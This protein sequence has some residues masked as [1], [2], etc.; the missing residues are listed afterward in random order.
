[1]TTDASSAYVGAA[2][3]WAAGPERLYDRLSD[4]VLTAVSR[5]VKDLRVLDAGAGTGAMSRALRSRGARPVGVDAAPD[6]VAR[7][8][9]AGIEAVD[10][11]LRALPFGDGEFDG[12]V[13][14]FAISHI[15]DP[16]EAVRELRRVVRVRGFV[17]VAAF[18][19]ARE[20]GS[21]QVVDAVAERYG[22]EQPAW[23]ERFKTEQETKTDSEEKLRDIAIRAGLGQV[24]ILRITVDAGIDTARD[25]VASRIGMAYLAPFVASLT[26]ARRAAFI[27]EAEADVARNFEP[28][29]PDVL[30]LDAIVTGAGAA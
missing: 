11:D 28:L 12:A 15:D 7:M 24:A 3:A 9:A 16:V 6:M 10:G 18:A 29:R 27:E 22:W 2:G 21:K 17:L 1:M 4:A 5:Q 30:V 19:A 26:E 13:A 23:Y 8:R 25:V 20:R 14:A